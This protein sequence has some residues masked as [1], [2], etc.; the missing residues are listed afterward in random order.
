M[1]LNL[2]R[3]EASLHRRGAPLGRL[4]VPLIDLTLAQSAPWKMPAL[5]CHSFF[6]YRKAI[7]LFFYS[8]ELRPQQVSMVLTLWDERISVA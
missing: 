7:Q 5:C 3:L 2:P 6:D 4:E 8:E 1:V